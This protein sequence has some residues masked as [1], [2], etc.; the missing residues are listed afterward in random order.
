MI[1]AFLWNGAKPKIPLSTLLLSKRDGEIG[2]LN[3][4]MR[5]KTVKGTWVQILQSEPSLPIGDLTWCCY[6]LPGNVGTF[7]KSAFWASVISTWKLL[8]KQ[9]VSVDVIGDHVIWYNSLI[10][11]QDKPIFYQ[12]AYDKGLIYVRQLFH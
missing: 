9:L 6:L 2:L 1:V 5:D 3:L 7:I 8:K 4:R 12:K 11:V 10:R